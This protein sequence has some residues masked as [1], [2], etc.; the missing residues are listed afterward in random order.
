MSRRRNLVVGWTLAVLAIA[1][2]ARLGLWQTQRAVEKQAMLA[3]VDKVL[4]Q[5]QAVP[6]AAAANAARAHDYDWSA[7][8]GE[9]DA[10]G[11]LWLDNQQRNGRAGVHAYRLFRPEGAPPLLVDLGWLPLPGNRAMPAIA[12]P[13][14]RMQLRGLLTAP[15]SAG[16]ALGRGIVR[17]GDGWVLTRIDAAVVARE[18]HLSAPLAPRV[19]RLDP[20]LPLGYERDLQLLANT[21]PP[22]RHRG[23]ALQ[24][25]ALA[26]AVLVTALILT[27]RKARHER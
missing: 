23:Y 4:A 13:A 15:P 21:L 3:A 19:L 24:W 22:D 26:T 18:L 20:A 1:L 7:G 10:R 27:F 16:L 11:P 5:R 8:W 9:F 12:R 25:F 17:Q 2:F 14:G 6:L